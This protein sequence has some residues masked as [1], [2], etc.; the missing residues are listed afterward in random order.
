MILTRTPKLKH[1]KFVRSKGNVYAYFDTGKRDTKGNRVYASLPKPATTGFMDSYA[2][3]LG[4]R[5]RRANPA[6]SVATLAD[7]FESSPEFKRLSKG[8]QRLYS[9]T[10]KRICEQFGTFPVDGVTPRHVREVVNNRLTGNGARNIFLSVLGLLYTF[11]RRRELT[12]AEPTK[13]VQAFRMGQH[14]PWPE[15]LLQ[16]G[17]SADHDRTRLAI[18]LLYHTGQR[19]GDVVK[20][21]WSD[22]RDGWLYFTQEKTRKPM[23]VPLHSSLKDE[24]ARTRKI[25]ITILGNELGQPV[26]T[27]TIRAELK[28]FGEANGEQ[29]VP[30]GLRKNAVNALLEAGCSVAEVAAI[31]GQ[32][33]Q[34][35]EHYARRVNQKSLGEAAIIKM[36][37]NTNVQPALQTPQKR[38]AK[39]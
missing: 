33:F 1:V 28:A 39:P 26:S 38:D 16:A 5:A 17:L 13:D 30:H 34:T 10:L 20:F 7:T 8:S 29:I 27:E 32:T 4:H 15:T 36:E 11:A 25:G 9:I 31:T 6:S 35:V 23:S 18:A 21:R 3:H 19:I 37:R 14:E 22:V 24:L 2:T 12:T